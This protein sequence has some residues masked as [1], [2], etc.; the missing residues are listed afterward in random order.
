MRTDINEK[1]AEV[2]PTQHFNRHLLSNYYVPGA[3][4]EIKGWS[5]HR[6]EQLLNAT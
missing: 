3:G 1:T 2:H 5:A 6:Q 4:S